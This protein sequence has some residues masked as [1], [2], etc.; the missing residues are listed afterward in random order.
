MLKIIAKAWGERS[1][2]LKK[3]VTDLLTENTT[4]MDIEYKDIVRLAFDTILYDCELD[5]DNIHEIDDGDYQG[6][7]AYLIPFNVYTPNENDYLMTYIG[8]GSC[9]VCDV[10]QRISDNYDYEELEER[11]TDMMGVCKDI[12][13]N[14]IRPYNFG[15]RKDDEWAE[16]IVDV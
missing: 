2:L 16:A 11:V 7:L 9:E 12:L 3:E 1:E 14:T 4:L 8:Y 6:I 13:T 10:L 15:W 5:L